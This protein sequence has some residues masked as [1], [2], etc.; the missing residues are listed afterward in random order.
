MALDS[1]SAASFYQQQS[2]PPGPG[3]DEQ[4]PLQQ[5]W[6][7]VLQ[8]YV[9]LLR[10]L[11]QL[12]R[13]LLVQQEGMPAAP[14][15]PAMTGTLEQQRWQLDLLQELFAGRYKRNRCACRFLRLLV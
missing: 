12:E 5:L 3:G 13:R 4:D 8:C 2:L 7:Q 10:E 11:R 6:S 15:T 1:S 9:A 14:T